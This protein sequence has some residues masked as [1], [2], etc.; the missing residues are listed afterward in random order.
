MRPGAFLRSFGRALFILYCVEVGV[1]LT[2]APW[3]G[4]WSGLLIEF[5]LEQLREWMLTQWGRGAVTGFGLVH[6]VWGLHDLREL[7][8]RRRARAAHSGERAP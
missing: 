6:V 1:F 8:G 5:P 4:G 2:L 3:R 7:L